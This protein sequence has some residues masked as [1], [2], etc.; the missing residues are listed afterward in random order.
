M[1]SLQ[2]GERGKAKINATLAWGKPP[3]VRLSKIRNDV[4][5]MSGLR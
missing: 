4:L 5:E 1:G 3:Q 2:L